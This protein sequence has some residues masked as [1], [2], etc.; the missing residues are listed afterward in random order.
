[1][2]SQF[3]RII[4]LICALLLIVS[5]LS[6]SACGQVTMPT[7]TTNNAD[8]NIQPVPTESTYSPPNIVG[9]WYTYT[10]YEYT[11]ILFHKD[12]S[13]ELIIGNA[14]DSSLMD[15][16]SG[17]YS[18]NGNLITATYNTS[19]GDSLSV[20]FTYNPDDRTLS[21][22]DDVFSFVTD[23]VDGP[24]SIVGTWKQ[25]PY[26]ERFYFYTTTIYDSS[27]TFY[28][29]GSFAIIKDAS[30]DIKASGSYKTIH[31][32]AAIQFDDFKGW[33]SSKVMKCTLL[34][35]NLLY[36]QARD[37]YSVDYIWTR[38]D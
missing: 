26:S 4:S 3:N 27:I 35:E 6:L 29:D 18:A 8:K 16:G 1:M 9:E 14:D 20:D 5:A 24:F 34:S 33:S 28:R 21:A 15:H 11:Y 38:I 36:I 12:M 30:N 25:L 7:S 37:G 23:N 22:F 32:G 31:D 19:S 2:K 10:E 17:I 13:F